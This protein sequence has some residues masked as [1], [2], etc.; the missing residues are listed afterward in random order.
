MNKFN[1][2]MRSLGQ[3]K[4]SSNELDLS[5]QKVWD[6]LS[7]RLQERQNMKNN[8]FGLNPSLKYSLPVLAIL[9]V[10][11]DGYW[12]GF[13]NQTNIQT[14]KNSTPSEISMV[15][16][17]SAKL[18][19]SSS[20]PKTNN[21]TKPPAD[22][23]TENTNRPKKEISKKITILP[24]AQT[25]DNSKLIA[26][27]GILPKETFA[28]AKYKLMSYLGI[29]SAFADTDNTTIA[30]MR[31]TD[32]GDTD[33][34]AY[35]VP[36][37]V[38][39]K[40]VGTEV[41]EAFPMF[42]PDS[43]KLGFESIRYYNV[44]YYDLPKTNSSSASSEYSYKYYDIYSKETIS[45]DVKSNSAFAWSPDGRYFASRKYLTDTKYNKTYP[46][47][48]YKA[49]YSGNPSRQSSI[50]FSA[51]SSKLYSIYSW[52]DKNSKSHNSIDEY[53]I[54]TD[55]HKDLINVADGYSTSSFSIV[56][57]Y[58]VYLEF[59]QLTNSDSHDS[60][61]KTRLI[62]YN[63]EN[64]SVEK[65]TDIASDFEVKSYR[66]FLLDENGD[67]KML[68]AEERNDDVA[69]REDMIHLYKIVDGKAVMVQKN[70]GQY[71][72]LVGWL[73]STQRAL[74]A[75]DDFPANQDI[76]TRVSLRSF[77]LG[78]SSITM[79]VDK[80]ATDISVYKSAN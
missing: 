17:E 47:S 51:D 61:T 43:S 80:I 27:I 32:N 78:T 12:F 15:T 7:G 71:T 21:S 53:D 20:A 33:I 52:I 9:I 6:N 50:G 36:L 14:A 59:P 75:Y 67:I 25:A 22:S 45:P 10:V 37:G 13:G 64:N 19:Q 68:I 2:A 11:S 39:K 42:S 72:K 3:D 62:K 8:I 41:N 1:N 34:W 66:N 54:Y 4:I 48:L 69:E 29:K 26:S 24:Q 38:E 79:L 60:I 73:G 23:V 65:T 57:K 16:D 28:L 56:G 44:N 31:Q 46:V 35:S 18:P 30:F 58:L 55:K 74:L 77:D 70:I 49:G 63:L 5:R 76:K 40:I